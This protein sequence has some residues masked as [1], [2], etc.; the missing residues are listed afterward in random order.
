MGGVPTVNASLREI[1]IR[2]RVDH[3]PKSTRPTNR[4]WNPARSGKSAGTTLQTKNQT[5]PCNLNIHS[6]SAAPAMGF[7]PATESAAT[8]AVAYGR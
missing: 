5:Q 7:H 1:K 4:N 8:V 3:S 2:Q 6:T